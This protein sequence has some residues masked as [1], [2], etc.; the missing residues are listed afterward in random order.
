VWALAAGAL[1]FGLAALAM[2]W[3]IAAL[4]GWNVSAAVYIAWVWLS[5]GRMDGA[6]TSEV[7]TIE[8][9]SRPA[10]DVILLGASLASLLGVGF[11][12]VEA[13][14]TSG[15]ARGVMIAVASSTLL[16]SWAAVHTVYTLRYASLYY[17]DGGGIDFNDDRSPDYGDFAY[18]AFTI[19]MT[20]QVSDTA[21][22][23]R[24]IRRTALRHAFLSY[25]FGTGV[26]AMVVNVVSGL[27]NP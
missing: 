14:A 12:L 22:R 23:S 18:V 3:Q 4:T 7:A 16:L 10:A 21:V 24:S 26:V 19:G 17:A 13:A 11:A 1:A 2:P 25:L 6:A 8:D 15:T 20:Y 5:V 9:E 27:I